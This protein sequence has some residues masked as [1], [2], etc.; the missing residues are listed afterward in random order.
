MLIIIYTSSLSDF[1]IKGKAKR[2]REWRAA[3]VTRRCFSEA[4]RRRGGF[5]EVFPSLA[6][7]HLRPPWASGG[8]DDC[9]EDVET[10][11][12]VGGA[13]QRPFQGDFGQAAQ[14]E[15]AEADAGF[16]DAEGRFDG[17]LALLVAGSTGLGGG[18]VG[19]PL[20]E[21]GVF[22]WWRRIGPGFELGDG[23]AVVFAFDGGQDGQAVGLAVCVGL[24]PGMASWLT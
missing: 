18:A 19:E 13:D 2:R 10:L 15:A 16:D 6:G 3:E 1:Q 21:R 12:V 23:A 11:E 8:C 5:R 4:S 24:K 9:F 14:Q 7:R 20:E 22:G 17:L